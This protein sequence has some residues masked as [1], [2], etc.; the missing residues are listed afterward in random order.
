MGFFKLLF[1]FLLG[2]YLFRLLGFLFRP[3]KSQSNQH[4][5]QNNHRKEGDVSI[6]LKQEQKKH[7][8]KD[9]GDYIDYEE[10]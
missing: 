1:L 10:V 8:S 5:Q 3:R 4:F 7:I 6:N 2:Y 9:D